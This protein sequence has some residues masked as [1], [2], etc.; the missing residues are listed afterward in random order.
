MISKP[1]RTAFKISKDLSFPIVKKK[2]SDFPHI[3]KDYLWGRFLKT[4]STAVILSHLVHLWRSLSCPLNPQQEILFYWEWSMIN[5][6][7]YYANWLDKQKEVWK[8]ACVSKL[9]HFLFHF[10]WQRLCLYPESP[11]WYKWISFPFLKGKRTS[12]KWSQSVSIYHLFL[13]T[14]TFGKAPYLKR[15][16]ISYSQPLPKRCVWERLHLLSHCRCLS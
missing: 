7:R 15:K 3:F 2:K 5:T 12:G 4:V 11:I 1:K 6:R 10:M 16:L 8:A 9:L 13:P 14:L